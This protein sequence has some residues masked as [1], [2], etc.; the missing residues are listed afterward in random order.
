MNERILE[1][2]GKAGADIWGDQASAGGHFNIEKFAELIV[3]A[4]IEAVKNTNTN[5]AFTTYDQNLI[6]A[7]VARSIKE[8]TNQ[9]GV[10]NV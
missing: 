9:F 3:Q 7:T 1:L 8:I 6:E 5:H 4:C 10:S 2:A